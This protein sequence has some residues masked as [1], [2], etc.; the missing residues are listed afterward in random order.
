MCLI[1]EQ[2]SIDG[3]RYEVRGIERHAVHFRVEQLPI[4]IGLVV[5]EVGENAGES[6]SPG[7]IRA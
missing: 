6:A 3:K 7:R 5:R 2:V 1:G 4:N